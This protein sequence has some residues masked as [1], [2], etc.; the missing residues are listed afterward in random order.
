MAERKTVSG[1]KSSRDA[2]PPLQG[3][4]LPDPKNIG[5]CR[6]VFSV[7]DIDRMYADLKAKKVQFVAPLR[8]RIYSCDVGFC[9]VSIHGRLAVVPMRSRSEGEA[10]P[11]TACRNSHR[12]DATVGFELTTC[13]T[14]LLTKKRKCQ[15]C[16]HSK[17]SHCPSLEGHAQKDMGERCLPLYR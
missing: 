8:S 6:I 2:D 13:Q 14:E 11:L 16:T 12:S 4:A 1:G 5:I 17:R 3:P 15:V 7:D 9:D 10:G